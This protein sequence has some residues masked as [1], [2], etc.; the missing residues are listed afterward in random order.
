MAIS[1]RARHQMYSRLEQ[2]L[3][4]DEATTLM[5]HLPPVGW[6]DVATKRDLDGL[7]AVLRTEIVELGAELRTEIADL[8]TETRTGFA[9]L[10]TE[11]SREMNAMVFKTGGLL[12]AIGGLALAAFRALG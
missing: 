8:R 4:A 1:E 7:G 3:G 2:V 12:V 5:E 11:L 6:A 9:D 10:R